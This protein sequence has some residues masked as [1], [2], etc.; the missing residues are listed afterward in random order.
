[1]EEDSIR[2]HNNKSGIVY[3]MGK[4]RATLQSYMKSP[5]R[6]ERKNWLMSVK[7]VSQRKYVTNII[8]HHSLR[9]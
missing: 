7:E 4:T 6:N 1:L 2:T 3:S 8:V 9:P 5:F